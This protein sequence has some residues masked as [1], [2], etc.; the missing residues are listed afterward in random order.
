MER[1]VAGGRRTEDRQKRE[2]KR[3]GEEV[4]VDS[5]SGDAETQIGVSDGKHG[6]GSRRLIK[7]Q[8][9]RPRA[10]PA[11]WRN[12]QGFLFASTPSRKLRTTLI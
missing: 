1:G 7:L 12:T 2:E 10:P 8:N 6:T 3:R 9:S 11:V 4:G 5:F